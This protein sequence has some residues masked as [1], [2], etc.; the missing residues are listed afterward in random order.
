M[1]A[2]VALLFSLILF[3]RFSE[4]GRDFVAHVK[5]ARAEIRKVV[6]PDQKDVISTTIAVG[7]A[8]VIFSILVSVLDSVLVRVLATIIG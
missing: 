6:W 8:V 5:A 3:L 4:L 2:W 1:W 7:I